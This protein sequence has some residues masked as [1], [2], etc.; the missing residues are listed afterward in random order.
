MR[1]ASA[2]YA[3]RR[4]NVTPGFSAVISSATILGMPCGGRVGSETLVC[5]RSRLLPPAGRSPTI[6]EDP[7]RLPSLSGQFRAELRCTRALR[8]GALEICISPW[9]GVYVSMIK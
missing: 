8:S 7:T 3:Y 9:K 2:F 1:T 4:V 6:L 5:S